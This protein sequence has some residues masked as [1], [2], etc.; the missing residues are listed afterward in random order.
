MD[1][2]SRDIK[3]D[4]C[5]LLMQSFLSFNCWTF[6][7]EILLF[8]FL[9]FA[10]FWI[11]KTIMEVQCTHP[12][13]WLCALC[14]WCCD[15]WR[16]FFLFHLLWSL[17]AFVSTLFDLTKMYV[18]EECNKRRFDREATD[19]LPRNQFPLETFSLWQLISVVNQLK[20]FWCLF[21]SFFLLSLSL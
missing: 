17:S 3:I 2:Q 6:A 1:I 12:R 7:N 4:G 9:S 15:F 11:A 16:I 14:H 8:C 13:A 20:T 18:K 5:W 19:I 21:L 10:R